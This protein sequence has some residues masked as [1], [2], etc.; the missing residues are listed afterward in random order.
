MGRAAC[1]AVPPHVW[2]LVQSLDLP[3]L[4]CPGS[5]SLFANGG[6]EIAGSFQSAHPVAVSLATGGRTDRPGLDT[7]RKHRAAW[8]RPQNMSKGRAAYPRGSQC[9]RGEFL[10]LLCSWI[11][12]YEQQLA[13][14]VPSQ[15]CPSGG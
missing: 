5:H 8:T 11:W 1:A 15:S 9:G 7:G 4:T 6:S 3:R 10:R 2:D 13:S 14:V 12:G